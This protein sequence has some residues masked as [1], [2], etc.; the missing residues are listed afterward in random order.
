MSDD[1]LSGCRKSQ[2]AIK[3]FPTVVPAPD[4]RHTTSG[5]N[6]MKHSTKRALATVSLS[7]LALVSLS[8]V[9]SAG[10]ITG[11]GQLKTVKAASICAY[12][13]QNDG[14][15][16]PRLAVNDADAARRVQNYGTD[17]KFLPLP[18]GTPGMACK[19]GGE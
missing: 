14:F 4:R 15:H 8:G 13:G 5:G 11:N 1:F 10:E 3:S 2:T 16:I 9:A 17:K 12:S 6:H 7:G 19:P 18:K